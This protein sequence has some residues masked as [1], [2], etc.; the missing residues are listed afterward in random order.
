MTQQAQAEALLIA[1]WLRKSN[2]EAMAWRL[3]AADAIERLHARVQELE[4]QK[5]VELPEPVAWLHSHSEH[6]IEGEVSGERLSITAKTY[7]WVETP[8]YTEQQVRA[9]VAAHAAPGWKLVP[10]MATQDM[11]ESAKYGIDARLSV[12]KW[13][14][15]YKAMLAAAPT[16]PAN[17]RKPVLDFSGVADFIADN[18]PMGR[19]YTVAEIESKLRIHGIGATNAD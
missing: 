3:D 11:C 13:A 16:P 18:W 2:E 9:M 4:A 10:E 17:E 7:G 14:D 5:A 1:A 8:L 12:F 19:R 6:C 15:G